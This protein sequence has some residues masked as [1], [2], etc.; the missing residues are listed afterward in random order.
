M[1][2]KK[3]LLQKI[4]LLLMI[5]RIFLPRSPSRSGMTLAPGGTFKRAAVQPN[6]FSYLLEFR[7]FYISYMDEHWTPSDCWHKK[8]MYT[9]LCS[10][11]EYNVPPRI[12][13]PTVTFC[14]S[15]INAF[16]NNSNYIDNILLGKYL[17]VIEITLKI[18]RWG[19][20]LMYNFL[21]GTTCKITSLSS[22]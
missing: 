11:I 9:L 2:M 5:A 7:L 13:T 1:P 10:R 12:H 3:N 4:K 6:T 22:V 18:Y 16:S 8:E 17:G 14:C 20:M 19:Y 15:V 21:T